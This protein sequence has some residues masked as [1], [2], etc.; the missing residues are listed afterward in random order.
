MNVM[1]YTYTMVGLL[2][3]WLFAGLFIE[4]NDLFDLPMFIYAV[5]LAVLIG[6][7]HLLAIKRYGTPVA[8][9]LD[10]KTYFKV[11]FMTII[12]VVITFVAALGL[13]AVINPDYRAELSSPFITCKRDDAQVKTVNVGKEL[14]VDGGTFTIHS[15]TTNVPQSAKN[16]QPYTYACQKATLA[17]I[18]VMSNTK[19][20]EALEIRD[21]E[22]ITT[23]DKNGITAEELNSSSQFTV[24]AKSQKLTALRQSRLDDS[25]SERGL[26]AFPMNESDNGEALKLVFDK[27]GQNKSVDI[28]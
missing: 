3:I 24:Y 19:D 21:L 1:K 26:I 6:G 9:D 23:S 11:F 18:S 14:I 20:G 8:A 25:L 22:L 15:I 27:Y 4:I 7:G 16:P 2:C 13:T 28:R 17:D 12:G 10:L 5:A